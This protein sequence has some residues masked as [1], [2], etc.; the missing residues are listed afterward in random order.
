MKVFFTFF[1]LTA[2]LFAKNPAIY[3]ALGDVIYDNVGKV[4]K[5][6]DSST[7]APY[8]KEI[9]KY[10]GDVQKAKENGLLLELSEAPI[11]KKEYLNTLRKLSKTNDYFMRSANA[12]YVASMRDNNFTLFSDMINSGIIDTQEHKQEIIDYYFQHSDDINATGVIQNYL[13]EDAKLKEKRDALSKHYKSKKMLEQEKI[14]RIREND[15]SEQER[16]EKQLQ[17]E[18]KK[19]KLEIREYQKKELTN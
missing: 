15:K 8:V 13:D 18:V 3:A 19:K 2:L 5:L 11:T 9:E 12:N 6:K 10:V 1:F 16:L 4:E 17:E 7:Y 14:D